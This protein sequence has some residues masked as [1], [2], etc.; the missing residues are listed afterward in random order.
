MN[1]ATPLGA[2][3]RSVFCLDPAADACTVVQVPGAD[4]A[5]HAYWLFPVVVQ[6]PAKVC[7]HLIAA[8]FDVTQGATKLGCMVNYMTAGAGAGAPRT[9]AMMDHV[10][11]LPTHDG[12]PLWAL[13]RMVEELLAVT[14]SG[15]VYR[16]RPPNA[17]AR[18]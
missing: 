9:L 18:L 1:A 17:R 11:Y 7:A 12:M 15:S 14:A 5:S 3:G 4:A 10:V 2:R 16:Y 8:G 13:E 6:D